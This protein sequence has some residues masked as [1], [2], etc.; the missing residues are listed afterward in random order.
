MPRSAAEAARYWILDDIVGRAALIGAGE[1]VQAAVD[2]LQ[3]ER[4]E[5]LVEFLGHG[6]GQ[7]DQDGVEQPG[8][9]ELQLDA[10][11][12][13]DPEVGQTQQAFDHVVAA[14]Y[15]AT[16]YSGGRRRGS[17]ALVRLRCHVP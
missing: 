6:V 10:V 3:R 5:G 13:T 4:R 9:P 16:A 15:S 14:F 17:N 12:G 2:H 7:L 1:E 8:R 11:G